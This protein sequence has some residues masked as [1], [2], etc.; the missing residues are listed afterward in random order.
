M[1]SLGPDPSP[2]GL[3]LLFRLDEGGAVGLFQILHIGLCHAGRDHLL[4][5]IPLRQPEDC[6]HPPIAVDIED[7]HP[8]GSLVDQRGKIIPGGIAK[9]LS[10]FIPFGG[11]RCV[12]AVEPDFQL[13]SFRSAGLHRVS[14]RYLGNRG[15]DGSDGCGVNGDR[16][17]DN[18]DCKDGQ[19]LLERAGLMQPHET[20]D[21]C[22]DM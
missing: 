9:G 13:G 19:Q 16:A 8:D 17:D 15:G 12:D 6:D 14:V 4:V 5:H 7:L 20:P 1:A 21:T 22:C 10:R 3:G 18:Q 2:L 11:L